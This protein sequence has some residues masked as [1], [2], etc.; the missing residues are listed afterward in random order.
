M[1][2]GVFQGIIIL[3]FIATGP[4]CVGFV[5]EGEVAPQT[6]RDTTVLVAGAAQFWAC[7]AWYCWSEKWVRCGQK[8]VR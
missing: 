3:F 1:F 2:R 8:Q 4:L 5:L 6:A 7:W